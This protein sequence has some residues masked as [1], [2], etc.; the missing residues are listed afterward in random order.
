ML[1]RKIC[2]FTSRLSL[3][4]SL[5]LCSIMYI[6]EQTTESAGVLNLNELNEGLTREPGFFPV[7]I[8]SNGTPKVILGIRNLSHTSRFSILL[9]SLIPEPVKTYYQCRNKMPKLIED[10]TTLPG[11]FCRK[12]CELTSILA[13]LRF[14]CQ[15]TDKS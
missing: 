2:L 3:S 5:K 7:I 14:I 11:T 6:V 9:Q 15:K 10:N 12:I 13:R 1:L 4:L 8:S